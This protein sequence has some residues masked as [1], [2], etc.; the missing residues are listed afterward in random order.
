MKCRRKAKLTVTEIT[1]FL[2]NLIQKQK[3]IGLQ[4]SE[5]DAMLDTLLIKKAFED[6]YPGYSVDIEFSTKIDGTLDVNAKVEP[7]MN[8]GEWIQYTE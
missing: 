5:L 6:M 7:P 4:M 2:S 1:N 8:L 3:I